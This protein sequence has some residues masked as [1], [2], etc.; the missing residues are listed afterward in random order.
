[1]RQYVEQT[2]IGAPREDRKEIVKAIQDG[3]KAISAV[4]VPI[5]AD[6][7]IYH[8]S[9]LI[10]HHALCLRLGVPCEE[11]INDIDLGNV[12]YSRIDWS[13]GLLGPLNAWLFGLVD[14]GFDGMATTAKKWCQKN[15]AM[16]STAVEAVSA[17]FAAPSSFSK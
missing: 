16:T 17:N 9:I 13:V 2:M 4:E 1:M 10:A 5:L 8:R 15:T 3:A 11:P 12:F 6:N 14:F 7:L